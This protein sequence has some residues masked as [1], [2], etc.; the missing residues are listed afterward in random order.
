MK[1]LPVRDPETDHLL[2]PKNS[3]LIL[4]DYQPPQICTVSSMDKGQLIHNVVALARMAKLFDMPIVLSTVNVTNGVN[5]PTIS[6]LQEVLPDVKPIDRTTINSWEDEEFVEAVKATGRKKLIMAALWT[7]AC[8]IFPALD[9]LVEGFQ[10]YPVTDAVG[11]TTLESH[12]TAI[13]SMGLAGARL[14]T[15]NSILCELQRDWAR[16]Q[17]VDGFVQIAT[18]QLSSWGWFFSLWRRRRKRPLRSRRRRLRKL[19]LLGRLCIFGVQSLSILRCLRGGSYCS[20]SW[21]ISVSALESSNSKISRFFFH[22]HFG[23]SPREWNDSELGDEAEKNLSFC[24]MVCLGKLTETRAGQD[25]WICGECPKALIGDLSF[26]APESK[27]GV[28]RGFRVE[29]VL[30]NLGLDSGLIV[31]SL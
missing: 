19:C 14:T 12:R 20:I 29:S 27:L 9:A 4:I 15:W 22:M 6:Q 10:V 5:P 7:E 2:T 30:D 1:S 24:F 13:Q 23:A 21:I 17:T 28:I 16:T 3:M 25:F 18:E 26:S 31:E 8:L 11:S